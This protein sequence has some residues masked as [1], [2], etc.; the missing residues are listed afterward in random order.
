MS[1]TIFQ[2]A[3][4]YAGVGW[5]TFPLAPRAKTPLT[6][7]G[8]KD[9]TTDAEKIS[10]WWRLSPGANVAIVTGPA[11]FDVLDV[12]GPE[13]EAALVELQ[14]KHGPLPPTLE[15]KT[16]RGRQLLFRPCGFPCSAGKLGKGLDTRGLGGYVAAP[17]SIHPNG[18]TYAWVKT[19]AEPAEAPAWLV[20]L[21][22]AK[23]AL[24]PPPLVRRAPGGV[25]RYVEAAIDNAYSR[26][27]SAPEGAR[28]DTLNRE[29]H[30]IGRLVAAG[31]MDSGAAESVLLSAA[32]AAG[33][34]E[35]EA[36]R[37]IGSGF[38]AGLS[39]PKEI[40]DRGARPS[41]PAAVP[42]VPTEAYADEGAEERRAI[43]EEPEAEGPAPVSIAD[44]IAEPGELE[45]LVGG[46]I[47]HGSTTMV[48][49]EPKVGKS[50]LLT[51]MAICLAT[52]TSWL[53]FP[54]HAPARVLYVMAEGARMAFRNRV[55]HACETL[56]MDPKEIDWWIQPASMTDFNLKKSNIGRMFERSRAK[57]IILDTKGYFDGFC[58]END[59]SKWKANVMAPIRGFISSLGCA[60]VIVHHYGKA[61]AGRSRV[62]RGRGTSAMQGDVDHW[63]GL[64]RVEMT[65]EEEAR[66]VTYPPDLI[67]FKNRRDLFVEY[68]RYGSQDNSFRLDFDPTGGVFW[69][70]GEKERREK[71]EAEAAD[72][73]WK[74]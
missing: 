12:D 31:G 74:R 53:G 9:A 58:D 19:A 52:G 25:S 54:I 67:E 70:A 38:S 3:L 39:N 73:W 1:A 5:P 66:C 36:R 10:A 14:S 61:V 33:L 27:A 30:A 51:H 7:H 71:A 29:A 42:D 41:G 15:T 16:G 44:F 63:F 40:P 32:L 62:E 68:N 56:R 57:L 24:T 4:A 60:F 50:F 35:A 64:E 20:A 43:Q 45:W 55:R 28:N 49:A 72:S 65:P 22:L 21:L 37:T 2:A 23:P 59:A 34:T 6:S 18:A 13:G 48:A 46:I 8:F 17:P 11:S 47:A 26:V 69:L